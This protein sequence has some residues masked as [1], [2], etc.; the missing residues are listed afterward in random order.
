M[1]LILA[2]SS[3]YVRK[4]YIVVSKLVLKMHGTPD[5]MEAYVVSKLALHELF[6]IVH[7]DI[8]VYHQCI[9]LVECKCAQSPSKGWHDVVMPPSRCR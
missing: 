9:S 7:F 5:S 6:G 3:D 1:F 2:L 4:F 8:F